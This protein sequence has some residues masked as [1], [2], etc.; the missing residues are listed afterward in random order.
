M[1]FTYRVIWSEEDQEWVGLCDQYP[2]LSHLDHD[3]QAARDGI[4][5]LVE[6]IEGMTDE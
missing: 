3:K 1:L 6:N 5:R 2:R 4:Q